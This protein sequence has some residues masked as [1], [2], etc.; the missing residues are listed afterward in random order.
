MIFFYF[1]KT[2]ESGR[3]FVWGNNQ[4][5]QLGV[6][7]PFKEV[8]TKPTLVRQFKHSKVKVKDVAFGY[9]FS[10]I[11]TGKYVFQKTFFIKGNF[12]QIFFL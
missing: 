5:G 10:V 3:L 4:Y 1:L 2:L 6:M 11:L 12:L 9:Q 7:G 8:I